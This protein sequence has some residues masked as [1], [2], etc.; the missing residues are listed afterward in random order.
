MGPHELL[1]RVVQVLDRLGVRYLVTGSMA[2]MVYGEPRFT[3]DIDIVVGLLPDHA[4]PLAASFPEPEFYLSTEAVREAIDRRRQFNVIHP[5]SGLKVD[6]IVRKE[7]PFDQCRFQRARRIRTADAFEA[8]F[9]APEDVILKKLEY[10]KEGGS[11]KHLRDITGMLKV[12]AGEIDEAYIVEWADR[13][14][15]RPVWEAV[16]RRVRGA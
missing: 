1:G 10:Y 4:G 15:L 5:A 11:E 2:A 12:S 7:T 8:T 13:L 3:N 9:A 16:A 14:D 6:L